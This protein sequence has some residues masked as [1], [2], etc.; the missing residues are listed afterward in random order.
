[1]TDQR[2]D[3]K[4]EVWSLRGHSILYVLL[5]TGQQAA[6][7]PSRCTLLLQKICVSTG[8]V[9]DME[10]QC[11]ASSGY[12]APTTSC[13][14]MLNSTWVQKVTCMAFYRHHTTHRSTLT[15][16]AN[17]MPDSLF[18]PILQSLHTTALADAMSSLQ[19]PTPLYMT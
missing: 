15:V 14:N 17:S 6:H 13:S 9:Q 7:T 1:M 2:A 11:V 12:C 8:N 16:A 18:L 19:Q 5:L 4:A 10:D 3:T